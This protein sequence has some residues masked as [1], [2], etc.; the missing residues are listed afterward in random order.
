M[1]L[2]GYEKCCERKTVGDKSYSLVKSG[3]TVPPECI[4]SC[5]YAL[6]EDPSQNVCF[7]PGNET[8]ICRGDSCKGRN[9][10]IFLIYITILV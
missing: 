6:D 2:A 8:A 5:V 4:N 10:V 3:G 7:A 9:Y 1:A